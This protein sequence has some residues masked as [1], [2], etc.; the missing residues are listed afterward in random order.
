MPPCGTPDLFYLVELASAVK[1]TCKVR[2]GD[3]LESMTP[4]SFRGPFQDPT[5]KPHPHGHPPFLLK[6]P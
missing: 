1:P 2:L 3:E 5:K 6:L 4:L